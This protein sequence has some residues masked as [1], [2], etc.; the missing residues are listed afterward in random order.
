[1]RTAI[2]CS[3]PVTKMG[4]VAFS[5]NSLQATIGT[6]SLGCALGTGVK[7]RRRRRVQ[8]GGA[9]WTLHGWLP[10][11][12]SCQITWDTTDTCPGVAQAEV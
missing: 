8:E 2:S 4:V 3:W 10:T 1:M 12:V 5:A 6:N 7:S 11:S 9:H